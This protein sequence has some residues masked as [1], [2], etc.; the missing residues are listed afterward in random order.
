[1]LMIGK[2]YW[3]DSESAVNAFICLTLHTLALFHLFFTLLSHHLRCYA[4]LSLLVSK[5][6][7]VSSYAL[8]AALCDLGDPGWGDPRFP[9]SAV[10][11]RSHQGLSDVRGFR[12]LF[13]CFGW[14]AMPMP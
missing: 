3:V 4:A 13:R 2:G 8:L 7:F 5:C 14:F 9:H 12:G 6:L 10:L 11:L 1:M